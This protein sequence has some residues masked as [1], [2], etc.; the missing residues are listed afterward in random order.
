M[1][2]RYCFKTPFSSQR[3]NGPQMMMKINRFCG[4]VE[5]RD[6]FSLIL[7]REHCLRSSPSRISDTPQTGLEPAPK[8]RICWMKLC[9]SDNHCI[10]EPLR[11]CRDCTSLQGSTFILLF[12]HFDIDRAWNISIVRSKISGL[13]VNPLTVDAKYSRHNTGNWRQPIQIYLS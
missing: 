3:V 9:S 4:M 11:D 8:F 10:V 1:H 12:H 13:L 6:A 7:S 5:Q 2:D